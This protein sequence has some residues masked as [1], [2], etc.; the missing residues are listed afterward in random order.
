[1]NEGKV[2]LSVH[3]KR[4]QLSNTALRILFKFRTNVKLSYNVPPAPKYGYTDTK[5]FQ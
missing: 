1:M 2:M 3:F 5:I 4:Q